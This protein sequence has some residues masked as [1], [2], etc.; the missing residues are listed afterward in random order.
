MKKVE[1]V[2]YDRGDHIEVTKGYNKGMVGIVVRHDLDDQEVYITL[3]NQAIQPKRRYSWDDDDEE[4]DTSDC[5]TENSI[6]FITKTDYEV[7]IKRNNLIRIDGLVEPIQFKGGNFIIG[8]NPIT[9]ANA[10]KLSEFI[11][12]HAKTKAK[13]K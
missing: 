1:R 9:K 3:A 13:K 8:G 2:V 4:E 10:K 5:F 12:K 7:G 6:K 11:T